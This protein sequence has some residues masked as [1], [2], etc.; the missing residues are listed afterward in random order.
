MT[1]EKHKQA[2]KLMNKMI[3]RM[4]Q[5]VSKLNENGVLDKYNRELK[6]VNR[7][8]GRSS[9]EDID[10]FLSP[11]IKSTMEFLGSRLREDGIDTSKILEKLNIDM[12]KAWWELVDKGDDLDIEQLLFEGIEMC[13]KKVLEEMKESNPSIRKHLGILGCIVG[14]GFVILDSVKLL[15]VS[16][17][18]NFMLQSIFSGVAIFY[19]AMSHTQ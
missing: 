13:E 16:D 19:Q 8:I 5:V 1:R 14:I 3:L 12:H 9:R 4:R 10:E 6:K 18:P 7:E 11:I 17:A 15:T 2:I